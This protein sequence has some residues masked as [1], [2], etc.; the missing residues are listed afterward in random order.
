MASPSLNK[1]SLSP[2]QG[3]LDLNLQPNTIA[4]QVGSGQA[5]DLVPGQA[6]KMTT[7]A[8][9]L[10][11]VIAAAADSDDIFGFLNYDLKDNS[12]GALAIGQISM[13]GN[14][15]WMTA[16]GAIARGAK[17][18]VVIASVKVQTDAAGGQTVIGRALDPA[19]ADGDLIRVLIGTPV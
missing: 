1:F 9:G 4:V 18:N 13:R 2:V 3:Q 5:T 16:A 10:P 7:G 11:I 6:V 12:L 19:S 17:V 15:M 8:G 14:V